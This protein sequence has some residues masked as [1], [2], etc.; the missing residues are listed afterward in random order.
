MLNNKIITKKIIHFS[1]NP[2]R[3]ECK[4]AFQT[5]KLH[6]KNKNNT[7]LHVFAYGHFKLHNNML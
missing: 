1:S 2:L 3:K 4:I 7:I 5:F 6:N